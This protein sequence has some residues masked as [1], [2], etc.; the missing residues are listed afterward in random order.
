MKK[1]FINCL[2]AIVLLTGFTNCAQSQQKQKEK[3]ATKAV[4]K[5]SDDDDWQ[6]FNSNRVPGT[7]DAAIKDEK[8]SIEFYG[9]H[10]SQGR[11]FPLPELGTLPTGNIGTFTVTREAGKMSFRGVFE[12]GFGH[13]SYTFQQNDQFKNYLQERGYKDLDQQMMMA[14]F[15]TN[16]NKDYFE[17]LKANGYASVSNEQFKDLAEQDMNRGK[18]E[19]YF[20]L[21]KTE[22]Y[23]HQS[24]EKIIELREHGVSAK[25]VQ[26]FHDIGFKTIP[27][28]Q[29]LELRDHGV[30]PEFISDIKKMGYGDISLEKAKDLRDHGVSPKYIAGIQAMGYKVMSLDQAQELRDHG[31]SAEYIKG[32]QNLGYKDISLDK[33]RE[34]RDHGVNVDFIKGIQQLGFKDLSLDKAQEL[35]DHGVSLAYIQKVKSKGGTANTLDDYIKLKDSGF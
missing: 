34:L 27:L 12:G 29:A 33:A 9:E 5:G 2:S 21:F 22:N 8:V 11:N 23:G 35:R 18:M 4:S 31:V 26:G 1:L 17:F 15:F 25:F 16:I 20:N 24:L 14:V 13:G 28:D 30:H 10:W 7:W 19:E 6:S 32:M 3:A